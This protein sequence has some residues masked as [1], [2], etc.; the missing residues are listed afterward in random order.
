MIFMVRPR[1]RI[2][3]NAANCNQQR[4]IALISTTAISAKRTFAGKLC[5]QIANRHHHSISALDGP[6]RSDLA[7]CVLGLDRF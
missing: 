3:A 4:I 5:Q 7:P 2:W 6:K 1:L